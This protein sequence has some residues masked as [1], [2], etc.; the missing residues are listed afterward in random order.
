MSA[1]TE[2]KHRFSAERTSGGRRP[3]ATPAIRTSKRPTSTGWRGK[4]SASATRSRSARSAR[5]IAQTL[6]TGRYPTSTGM[7]LNDAYLPRD[8]L[9]L[10]EAL[11]KAGYATAYIGK[12]HLDGHGR[13]AFIPPER[14][15]GWDYWKAAECDHNYNHSHYYQGQS[16]EKRFWPGYD[17]FAQTEDAKAYLRGHAKTGRPFILMVSYGPPHFP[18]ATAPKQYQKLYPPEKLQLLPNVPPE[19]EAKVRQ[20]AQGYYAH[21]TALDRCIGEVMATLADA[22]LA[23]NTILVFTSDHGEM[24]GAH[25]CQVTLKQVAWDESAHVPFLLRYPAVHGRQGREIQTALTTPDIYP[26]LLGLAGVAVPKCVEGEDLSGLI[27]GGRERPDRAALYMAVA[28][29]GGGQFNHEYRAIRTSRYTCARNLQGPWLLFDDRQDPYQMNNLVDQPEFAATRRELDARLWAELK[30]IGDDFR[31]AGHYVKL[32]G[33]EVNRNGIIVYS[34]GA[35]CAIARTACGNRSVRLTMPCLA[36]DGT[37]AKSGDEHRSWPAYRRPLNSI[38]FPRVDKPASRGHFLRTDFHH[39]TADNAPGQDVVDVLGQLRQVDEVAHPLQ[40][41]RFPLGGQP[42]PNLMAERDRAPGRIDPGE[43]HG[44]ENEREN[45]DRQCVAGGQTAGG[46]ATAMPRAT[47]DGRTGCCRPR[48]PLL[49]PNGP[50]RA[51]CRCRRQRRRGRG[52]GPP[53]GP[54]NTRERTACR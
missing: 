5:R 26:T 39:H 25:G 10:A 45:R 43:R 6:M 11:K 35:E 4:A 20:E 49:P 12:W 31:P 52:A 21:C 54:A 7:F 29:F 19:M 24:L 1:F 34:P 23:E 28:P 33:Y 9:C 47:Q 27:R 46:H 3:R 17:A 41:R 50:T 30:K 42:L 40:L 16:S 13:D 18:H 37:S 15:H 48:Y 51:A 14:R 38:H 22:G 44:A 53:Q 36:A 32:W 8:E 2:A